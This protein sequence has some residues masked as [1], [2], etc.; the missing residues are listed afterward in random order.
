MREM[1]QKVLGHLQKIGANARLIEVKGGAPVV[2][3][4]IGTGKRTMMI[5][6][7]YDV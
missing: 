3:G 7:H 6:D 2:H 1:V 5:Y 4:E